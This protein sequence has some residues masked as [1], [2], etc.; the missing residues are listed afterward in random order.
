LLPYAGLLNG[1]L[2]RATGE[3]P[4]RRA[5]AE[6]APLAGLTIEKPA[7]NSG[8]LD[9][10]KGIGFASGLLMEVAPDMSHGLAD[11]LLLAGGGMVSLVGAG[12][13]TSLMYR[14]AH[15]LAG[16]GRTVLTTTSTRIH[17]PTPNQCALCILAPTAD[18]I[19]KQA[20]RP[21][22]QYRHIAAAAG[23]DPE[24]GKLS[25]LAP[26]EIDRLEASRAF[27]WIIVEADGAAGRPLKAPAAHE[28]VI[29]S[30]SGWVVGMVG[31]QAVGN[32]LTEQWVF[33]PEVFSR[34]TGLAPG[35]AI[36]EEAV[37]AA[38]AHRSGVLKGASADSRCMAFLN[39]AD[40]SGRRAAGRRIADLLGRIGD[41]P[42][43][44]TVVG[45]VLDD[46]P[47]ADVFD[48]S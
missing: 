31:L 23:R 27:D 5:A 41:A 12:G 19:L 33:R 46:P 44:R 34:I 10:R 20:A 26:E 14:L 36:T 17:P 37:A 15:E 18:G 6:L 13:K 35:A 3:K 9:I 47:V 7:L 40:S 29:P 48:R 8:R 1:W 2:R 21:L 32:P 22:R 4:P 16:S 43:Q 30:G 42:I 38:L 25:G 11:A 24:S 45:R 39:R 28:P